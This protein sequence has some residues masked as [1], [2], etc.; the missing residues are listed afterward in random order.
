MLSYDPGELAL[1]SYLRENLW[2]T[3]LKREA[4]LLRNAGFPMAAFEN[5][6]LSHPIPLFKIFISHLFSVLELALLLVLLTVPLR[7]L[8]DLPASNQHKSSICA[9][10]LGTL[11]VCSVS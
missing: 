7:W 11:H 8:M 6:A 1:E 4:Q 10:L 2:F 5:T 9:S 3:A